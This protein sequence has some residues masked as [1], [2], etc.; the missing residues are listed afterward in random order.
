MYESVNSQDESNWH[1]IIFAIIYS[2]IEY[3]I[4]LNLFTA[5]LVENFQK[6]LKSRE[7]ESK[8][9]K[10]AKDLEKE[11]D[12]DNSQKPDNARTVWPQGRPTMH[13][14]PYLEDVGHLPLDQRIMYVQFYNILCSLDY[15]S[16]IQ[17]QNYLMMEKL[18][19][20]CQDPRLL[21]NVQAEEE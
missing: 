11:E 13:Y 15:Q 9:D 2:L 5:V 21:H 8:L 16:Y 1:F 17:K 18:L 10:E 12:S 3:F 6:Q 7:E 14:N 19:D 4:F 20:K